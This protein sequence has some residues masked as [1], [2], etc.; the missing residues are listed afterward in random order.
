[1]DILHV[2]FPEAARSA[3]CLAGGHELE[4]GEYCIVDTERGPA[5]A[6]DLYEDRLIRRVDRLYLLWVALTLGIPF[7]IGYA[8]GGG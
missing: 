6:R 7:A 8:V 3:A 4:V 5:Y 1:M 2:R